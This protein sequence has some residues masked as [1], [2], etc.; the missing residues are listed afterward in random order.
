[1]SETPTL[2]TDLN[3]GYVTAR[4]L[5]AVADTTADP[6]RLPD[7]VA[8]SGT[9][10]FTP[11]QQR[12]RTSD[13][14]PALVLAQTVICGLDDHGYLLDPTGEVGVWLVTGIYGVSYRFAAATIPQHD[15]EVTAE[16]TEEL[17]LHLSHSVPPGGTALNP[18][19]FA[20]LSARIDS[21]TGPGGG[22][23]SIEQDDTTQRLYWTGV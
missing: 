20:A 17:P 22:G 13:P 21:I 15:I 2:P 6:D 8:A 14:A 4:L 10:M 7:A 12:T 18:S 11:K 9:V 16:H 23:G 5:L 19:E 1:M 3:Y